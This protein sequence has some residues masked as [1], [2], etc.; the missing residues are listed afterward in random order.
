MKVYETMT[1]AISDE[2]EGE[3]TL[4]QCHDEECKTFFLVSFDDL[5]IACDGT[6]FCP[7]CGGKVVASKVP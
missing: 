4:L 1:V 5:W 3:F 7:V 6:V 2:I